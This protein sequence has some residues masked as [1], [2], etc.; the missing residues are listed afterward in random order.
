MLWAKENKEK[1]SQI[2]QLYIQSSLYYE[3]HLGFVILADFIH[4]MW[5]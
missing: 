4:A 1:K 2:I 5:F 3:N